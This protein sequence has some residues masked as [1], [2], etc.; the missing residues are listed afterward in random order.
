MTTIAEL[1][2]TRDG[3]GALQDLRRRGELPTRVGLWLHTPR[4][5]ARR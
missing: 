2:F 3:I 1:P 5:P 4:K